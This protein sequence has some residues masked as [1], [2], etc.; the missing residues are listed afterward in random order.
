M[1]RRETHLVDR[2]ADLM[3]Q[4]CLFLSLSDLQRF[5]GALT[6]IIDDKKAS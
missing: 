3:D 2:F 1:R 5:G 6:E 4:E